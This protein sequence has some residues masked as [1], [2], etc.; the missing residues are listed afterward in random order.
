MM[1]GMCSIEVASNIHNE[2]YAIDKALLFYRPVPK[3][4]P[5]L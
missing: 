3:H 1:K 4:T 5:F 2:E